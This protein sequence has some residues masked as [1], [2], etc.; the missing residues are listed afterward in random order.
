LEQERYHVPS[1]SPT[2]ILRT[3]TLRCNIR[4]GAQGFLLKTICSDALLALLRGVVHG[5]AAITPAMGGR[6]L[7]EFRRLSSLEQPA[8]KDKAVSLTGRELEVLSLVARGATDQEIA[9]TLTIS[10]N[11]VKT[12][13]RN[14]LAKLH[15]SRRYQAAQ[16]ALRQG[17]IRQVCL[18]P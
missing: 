15:L 7:D 1:F 14:I 8:A 13:V 6:V 5:E 9:D 4:N 3:A 2:L 17:L 12:H 16:Y 11:T 18:M 10:I